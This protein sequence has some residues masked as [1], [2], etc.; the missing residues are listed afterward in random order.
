MNIPSFLR[1][2]TAIRAQLLKKYRF[3]AND[4]N[5]HSLKLQDADEYFPVRKLA[6]HG[7]GVRG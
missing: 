1:N 2:G 4:N 3:D 7:R 5:Y 6:D